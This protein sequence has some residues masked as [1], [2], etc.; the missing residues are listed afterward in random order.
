M[1]TMVTSLRFY[2]RW[3]DAEQRQSHAQGF[4]LD[5]EQLKQDWSS[6]TALADQ[7]GKSLEQLHI[8]ALAHIV[9]R[10]VIVYGVKLVKNF[11]GENLGYVN[12]EGDL[13]I[14]VAVVGVLPLVSSSLPSLPL[15]LLH[16]A[17]LL[18]SLLLPLRDLPA[19]A[20][21]G[22]L[23]L[24]GPHCTGLHPRPLLSS[25]GHQLIK[26]IWGRGGT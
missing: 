23:L 18:L 6:V 11:R 3:R 8:F 10:P 25:C 24:E 21:G 9:R 7:Q 12:F 20:L 17:L 16:L 15:P 5:E 14:L 13:E 26:A 4:S 19:T 22:Q 1:I 2:E